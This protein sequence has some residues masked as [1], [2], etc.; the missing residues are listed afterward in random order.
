[1]RLYWGVEMEA[2]ICLRNSSCGVLGDRHAVRVGRLV[3]G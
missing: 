3:V 1:M 2:S